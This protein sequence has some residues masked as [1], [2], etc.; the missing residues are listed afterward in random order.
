MLVELDQI[1]DERERLRHCLGC[2]RAVAAMQIATAITPSRRDGRSLRVAVL[3]AIVA[4][5]ALAAY[6]IA[7]Y[8][9]LRAGNGPWPAV[10]FLVVTLL[11][12]AASALA[13]SQGT[14][15]HA[16]LA[17][18]HGLVGGVIVG[19]AWLVA[20][21][22]PGSLKAWVAVPL[23]VA[24]LAPASLAAITGHTTGDPN[25]ATAT[26]AWSGLIGALLAFIVW[27]A[28]TYRRNG[29]P[30]DPQLLRDFH[31]SHSHDLVAYAV[32]DSLGTALSLLVL[33]P[34]VAL[35][36]GSL[37]RGTTANADPAGRPVA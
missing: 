25:A 15:R 7:H 21:N 5:L 29:G 4:S 37:T 28:A 31:R 36:L 30:Y 18:R 32:S 3:S 12:Y 27:V 17:R 16:S 33:I 19:T 22:P 11:V 13:L 9:G 14:T 26:A 24:L 1:D 23:A 35:A 8:P 20:I 6:G 10:A 2:V 34:L